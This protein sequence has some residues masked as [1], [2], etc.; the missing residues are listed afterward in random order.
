[1][2]RDLQVLGVRIWREMV[3]DSEKWKRYC[4]TDQS[5]QRALAPT[6]EEEDYNPYL[7]QGMQ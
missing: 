4:S 5:P 6:E 2:K 7:L 3:I 1:M